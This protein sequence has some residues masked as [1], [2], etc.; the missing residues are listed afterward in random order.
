MTSFPDVVVLGGG[1]AGLSSA[2]AA[3]ERGLRVTVVD[4]PRPGSASRAAAGMLAPSVEGLAAHVLPLAVEARD[5]YPGFL[6]RLLDS[7]EVV[8]PLDRSGIIEVAATEQDLASLVAR[9]PA[10]SQCLDARAL[11]GLEPAFATHPGGCLHPADGAV[12]NVTLMAALDVAVSRHPRVTRVTDEITSFDTRGS[13]PAFRSRAGT[14]YAS[15]RLL[16]A[17]GAWAGS[18][19]GLPRPLPI[20]PVRGQL[21]RLDTRPI[22]HVTYVAGGYLVP[23]GSSVLVGAT[24]EETGFAHRTTPGGLAALRRIA[25]SAIPVLAHAVVLDHWAGFRPVTP[26]AL[27]IVDVDPEHPALAYACGFSR[28]GILLAPWAAEHVAELLATGA[29]SADVRPFCLAR[30]GRD[31]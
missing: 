30:F 1:I 5:F 11:A 27:P 2:L 9:A 23:R 16:L 8:V 25:S 21:A 20:R 29:A 24:S 10:G 22:R 19:A 18:L 28:N 3:A 13:R 31:G 26:D 6:K 14:R 4:Q 15:P 7:T 12:D 17:S